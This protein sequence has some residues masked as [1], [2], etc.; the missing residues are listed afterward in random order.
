VGSLTTYD[1]SGG[2]LEFDG[3][4]YVEPEEVAK[5]PKKFFL[6]M[7]ECEAEPWKVEEGTSFYKYKWQFFKEVEVYRIE[8]GEDTS[9]YSK[10]D[11]EDE[12]EMNICF[13]PTCRMKLWFRVIGDLN[14]QE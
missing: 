2:F 10:V 11:D 1:L 4:F 13:F 8:K 12:G 9:S 6:S 7:H 5:N 3:Y 14:T